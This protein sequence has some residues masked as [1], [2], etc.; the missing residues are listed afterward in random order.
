MPTPRAARA[1]LRLMRREGE[2]EAAAA[3]AE[4]C[5]ASFSESHWGLRIGAIFII[6]VT[7]SLGT[8]TPIVLRKSNVVP[9]AFF[10]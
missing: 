4:E 10:E 8:I 1:A 5:A 7:S 2:E 9:R 3:L 6:L